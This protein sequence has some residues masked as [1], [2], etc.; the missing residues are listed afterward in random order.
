MK[1]RLCCETL[2]D[3]SEDRRKGTSWDNGGIGTSSEQVPAWHQQ[4]MPHD[5]TGTD[6]S[7]Y[8]P[9][10]ERHWAC[11]SIK[12]HEVYNSLECLEYNTE[13]VRWFSRQSCQPRK[14]DNPIPSSE[15]KS[16]FHKAVSWPDRPHKHGHGGTRLNRHGHNWSGRVCAHTH[17]QLFSTFL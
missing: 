14:P 1:K 13:P 4:Q 11:S 9:P 8:V 16:Q 2:T 12:D 10:W 7:D 5:N 17:I 3:L 6:S 15:G